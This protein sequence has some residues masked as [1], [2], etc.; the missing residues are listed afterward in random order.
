MGFRHVGQASFELLTSGDPPALASQS[1]GITGMS[2]HAQPRKGLLIEHLP[3]MEFRSCC[4][5]WNAMVQSR[6]TVTSTSRVQA[7][8][9][10]QPPN[11][12]GVSPWSGWS[13]TP[14]LKGSARLGLPKCCDYRREPPRPAAGTILN[15]LRLES[16]DANTAHCSLELLGSGDLP[17]LASKSRS[18]IQAVVCWCDPGSLQPPPPRFKR[19]PAS[20]FPVAG[21]TGRLSPNLIFVFLVET[22][23]SPCW[24]GWSPT[25]DLKWFVCLGLPKCWDYRLECKGAIIAHCNLKLLN[26]SD[27]PASVF[28]VAGTTGM[29]HDAQLLLKLFCRSMMPRLVL[30]FWPQ[31]ILPWCP[32]ELGLQVLG[33]SRQKSPTGSQRDSFGRRGCFASTLVQ[34]FSVR[35]IRDWVPF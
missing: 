7:I 22:G 20:A 4:P 10:P 19:F 6:F 18:V 21:I 28:Q 23:F 31:A 29:Y 35:S 17:T 12:D 8:L 24:P 11:R 2:H 9:L 13:Q 32:K 14:D 33:D 25:P 34:R 16:K 30:N 3:Q 15:I 27:P 26:S 5:G 1:S